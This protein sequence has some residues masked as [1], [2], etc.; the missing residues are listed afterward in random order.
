MASSR[1][2]ANDNGGERLPSA[3]QNATHVLPGVLREL[4]ADIQ[5]I[6]DA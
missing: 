4:P 5:S 1:R 2:E 6:V 3:T